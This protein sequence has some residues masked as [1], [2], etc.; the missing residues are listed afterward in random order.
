MLR[1]TRIENGGRAILKLEGSLLGPW[2]RE[3]L[4]VFASAD[5]APPT[6]LDLSHVTFVDAAGTR[7]LRDLIDRG[8]Q[9][10]ARS[11]FVAELLSPEINT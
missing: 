4:D 8:I 11:P 5:P 7:L 1:L 3:V 6:S 2:V 10:A 9:I